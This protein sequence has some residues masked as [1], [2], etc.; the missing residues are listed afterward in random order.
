[1]HP[2]LLKGTPHGENEKQ[3]DNRMTNVGILNIGDELLIGQVVN[4]NASRMAQMLT[5]ANMSVCTIEVVGDERVAIEHA[6]RQMLTCCNV[7]L[8]TGGLGPT[9]DDITKIV[10]CDYFHS[11]LYENEIALHNVERIFA[12]RGFPMTETNRRQA[13]VPRCCTV[14]NNDVGTAP[15]MWFDIDDGK[16]GSQAVIA[17]PG[18]PHEMEYLMRERVLPQLQ[19]RFSAE[20]CLHQTLLLHGVGESFLSDRL[21]PWELSLPQHIHLAYLPQAGL[22]RLRISAEGMDTTW[23]ESE[24]ERH[25]VEL[26]SQVADYLVCVGYE[27]VESYVADRMRSLGLTLAVAESCT[28]GTIAQMLTAQ[29]GCSEYFVGGVVAY[30]NGV[31]HEVLGVERDT[32]LTHG[33]VSKETAIQM[34]NGVRQK[35]HADYGLATT[36]VAGPGGGTPD[37]PVGTVWIALSS[38]AGTEACLLHLGNHRQHNIQHAATAVLAWLASTLRDVPQECNARRSLSEDNI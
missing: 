31:K 25:L 22:L 29:A 38:V 26:Q 14:L 3:K 15:C 37:K 13:L 7:V 17:M 16:L 9:K 27:T 23:T 10:L 18:V 12:R 32:L 8:I 1:M 2:I 21:E 4:T 5:L 35:L 34:A 6:L 28:G 19:K 36:G 20:Y 33:A 30:S 24:M 11:E